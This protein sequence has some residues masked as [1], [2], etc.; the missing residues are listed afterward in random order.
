MSRPTRADLLDAVKSAIFHME[1]GGDCL[2]CGDEH[3]CGKHGKDCAAA[4][5]R[6]LVEREEAHT[7]KVRNFAPKSR[8]AA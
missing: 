2:M 5:W 7:A 4:E 8:G 1:I 3:D 6:K